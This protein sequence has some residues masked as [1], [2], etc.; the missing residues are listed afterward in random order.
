MLS[1]AVLQS[2][3]CKRLTGGTSVSRNIASFLKSH[4]LVSLRLDELGPSL[5]N[6]RDVK[7]C[8]EDNAALSV[9]LL[10]EPTE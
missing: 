2:V 4:R 5:S 7:I 3:L 1:T 6:H 9:I 10:N 8:R